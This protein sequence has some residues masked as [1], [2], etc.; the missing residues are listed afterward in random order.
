MSNQI[1]LSSER[2][3]RLKNGPIGAFTDEL[4]TVFLE[5]GYPKRDLVA[6]FAVTEELNSWLIR[7]K[8]KLLDF[9]KHRIDQ[10]IRHR[11]K[12]KPMRRRGETVTLDLLVGILRTH[13]EIPFPQPEQVSQSEV[14]QILSRYNHHLVEVQGLSFSTVYNYLYRTRRFLLNIFGSRAIDFGAVCAQSIT[15]FIREYAP[16]YSCRESG[17]MVCA[18]RSFL[19]FLLLQGEIAVDLASCVPTV[20]N[21]RH[22]GVPQ[23]LSLQELEHLL[24]RSK[25]ESPLQIR[26]HAILL[27]LSRL[28]LRAFEVVALTLE[29]VDWEHGELIVNGKGARQTRFPLPVDVGEALVAYLKNGR[30][31]CSTRRF[32]ICS[33]A[34]VKPLKGSCTVSTIV[35]R[36]LRRAGLNPANKGAHLLRH[37]LATECLRQGATLPE[38]GEILRHKQIDTTAIYAKVDFTRLA[39]LAR[40]WPD[41]SFSGG[42]A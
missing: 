25:G 29:D 1:Y 34:P 6:R 37:T 36:C 27:L 8:I 18:L 31:S 41:P 38:V 7:E 32:F 2:E 30:P 28:G 15:R 35:R 33:R 12:Q 21:R 10:F 16:Q 13:G 3:Q 40:P 42:K 20:P 9:D 19:R 5:R 17:L 39:A 26:N 4:A 22:A 24:E 23:Y 14:E 11:S